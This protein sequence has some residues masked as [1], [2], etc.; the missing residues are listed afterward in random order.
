MAHVLNKYGNLIRFFTTYYPLRVLL[1]RRGAG[2][3]AT[4]PRRLAL[5]LALHLALQLAVQLAVQLTAQLAVS[6]NLMAT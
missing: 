1:Q 5:R 6:T 3:T 2:S 4:R